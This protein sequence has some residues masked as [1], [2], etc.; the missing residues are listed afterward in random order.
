M[1]PDSMLDPLAIWHERPQGS[2]VN[3]ADL[4][5]LDVAERLRRRIPET[6]PPVGYLRGRSWFRDVLAEELG[7]SALEAEQLVDTLEANG[8]LKFRGDPSIRAHAESRWDVD[9]HVP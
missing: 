5:L 2:G 7:C 6:E 1:P 8:Y 4:D 3:I 9:P